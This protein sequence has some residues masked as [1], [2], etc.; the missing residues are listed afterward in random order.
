MCAVGLGCGGAAATP[1]HCLIERGMFKTGRSLLCCCIRS[2]CSKTA[3]WDGILSRWDCCKALGWKDMGRVRFP[4]PLHVDDCLPIGR[5]VGSFRYTGHGC[6]KV[7]TK[8]CPAFD[9]SAHCRCCYWNGALVV[10]G[11]TMRCT[12]VVITCSPRLVVDG[13][14]LIRV[15]AIDYDKQFAW[16]TD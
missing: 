6:C 10:M 14:T 9:I 5:L 7:W 3:G 2:A 8:Q 16:G 13:V 4:V 15:A 12:L 1:W 11:P